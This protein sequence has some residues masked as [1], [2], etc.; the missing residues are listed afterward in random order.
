MTQPRLN[1]ANERIIEPMLALA[2]CS[3]Q[4]RIII[5]GSKAIEIMSVLQRRGYPR[6]AA[7][8]TCG[9][10]S[11]QYNAAL[12]DWRQRSLQVLDRTIEWLVDYMHPAAVLVV[13]VDPQKPAA[14]QNLRA[15]L[16]RRGFRIE[17]GTSFEYGSAVA[18]R[19]YEI[20][21]IAQAA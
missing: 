6:A 8:A 17:A 14:N 20:T 2:R 9:H 16:L 1:S 11:R 21:P 5:A 3:Q 13:W 18:A 7:T 4:D 15:A 10:A 19:R 12:V